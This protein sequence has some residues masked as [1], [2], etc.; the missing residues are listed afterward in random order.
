[1]NIHEA[2]DLLTIAGK[3]LAT[4]KGDAR[5]T[6]VTSEAHG[7][8]SKARLALAPYLATQYALQKRE[9]EKEE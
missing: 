2:Y 4:M 3:A 7:Y 9:D 1:M 5:M 6:L 8:V